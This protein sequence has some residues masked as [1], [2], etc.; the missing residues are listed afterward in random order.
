MIFSSWLFLQKR[1]NKF[2]FTTMK[3]QVDLFLFVFWRKLKTPKRYFEINWPLVDFQKGLQKVP[4][5]YFQSP[6]LKV[7]NHPNFFCFIILN[8]QI[9]AIGIFDKSNSRNDLFPK[10]MSKFSRLIWKTV[11]QKNYFSRSYFCAK[12]YFQLTLVPETLI[13]SN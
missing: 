1:T 13:R 3:P 10:L 11:N 5:S 7:K 6:F 2:Y 9:F 8:Y 4:S 12:I